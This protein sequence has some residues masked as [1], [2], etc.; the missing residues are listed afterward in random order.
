[1][2]NTTQ[3][4]CAGCFG[5]AVPVPGA[6]PARWGSDAA[7]D[8]NADLVTRAGYLRLA[9]GAS[10]QQFLIRAHDLHA[11]AHKLPGMQMLHESCAQDA[12]GR[13]SLFWAHDLHA[14]AQPLPDSTLTLKPQIQMP[15]ESCAQDA[16]GRQSLFWVH[17]LHAGAQTLEQAHLLP[18]GGPWGPDAEQP[19]VAPRAVELPGAGA[20]PWTPL[21]K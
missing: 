19:C 4:M 9:Q 14:G 13:Q 7:R 8:A 6:R 10:D 16:S 20:V 18:R 17:D 11:G 3:V 5:Q 12:S 21:R 2:R 1:M 15:T